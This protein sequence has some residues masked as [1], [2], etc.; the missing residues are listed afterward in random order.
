MMGM[1][2]I[3]DYGLSKD[4][5]DREVA[6]SKNRDVIDACIDVAFQNVDAGSL[7][8]VELSKRR[9]NGYYTKTLPSIVNKNGTEIRITD[10]AGRHLIKHLSGLDGATIIDGKGG[11]KDFGVTLNKQHT[12]MGHGKRHAF[13]LGTSKLPE[14]LCILASEE[15]KHVRIFRDGVC[16]VDIDS[17]TKLPVGLKHKLV[18]ILDAPLSKILV[19]SGI[20]TSI[21]TLNPI[22]AIITITGST[23][24]VSY[25]FD[26]LKALF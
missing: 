8:V 25:G 6:P 5:I 21:L 2:S 10:Q 12:F 15:D 14:T 4:Y 22:P 11:M 18:A 24:I 17:T 16:V 20:A 23:V 26:R 9:R 1:K 3:E 19:A 7:F 13:A